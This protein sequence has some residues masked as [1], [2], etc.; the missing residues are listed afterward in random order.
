M[1]KI[2]IVSMLILG[3]FCSGLVLQTA[4]EFFFPGLV[5]ASN[6]PSYVR[7][8]APYCCDG[9]RDDAEIQQAISDANE[10][11]YYVKLSTGT[12]NIRS[13]IKPLSNTSMLSETHKTIIKKPASK[14]SLLTVDAVAAEDHIHITDSNGFLAGDEVFIRADNKTGWSTEYHTITS[15]A[16]NIVYVTPVIDDTYATAQAAVL[17][18]EFP[19]IRIGKYTGTDSCNRD[20]VQIKNI[21]LDGNAANRAD[22][23][24]GESRNALVWISGKTAG[25]T[26]NVT[27]SNMRLINATSASF[28]TV[29]GKHIF[30]KDCISQNSGTAQRGFEVAHS[31]SDVSLTNCHE[32]GS[33]YGMYF[34]EG[35]ADVI[36]SACSFVDNT[37]Y[38]VC[39]QT[40]D[41]FLF[42]GCV[43]ANAGLALVF[44]NNTLSRGIFSG[45][46]FRGTAAGARTITIGSTSRYIFT[47]CNIVKGAAQANYSTVYLNSPNNI[48][49]GN[50]IG[51][52]YV[53]GTGAG[54][55][56]TANAANCVVTGNLIDDDGGT[57]IS[58][59]GSNNLTVTATDGDA[60]NTVK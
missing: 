38:A 4:S 53:S 11:D 31:S 40:D 7:L 27:I 52:E 19:A 50:Y 12:F 29:N 18:N 32:S 22:D 54:V 58:D 37:S 55:E 1:K 43:F 25:S 15:V 41:N 2:I 20:N 16:G 30:V 51:H 56:L 36:V 23:V 60:L 35:T 47:G 17:S 44:S 59:S 46:D 28:V 3:L 48:I 5:A 13:S 34:C 8:I 21:T 26:T 24:I 49:T 39:V 33:V 14:R 9:V 6:A 57:A 45:C 10:G 42:N